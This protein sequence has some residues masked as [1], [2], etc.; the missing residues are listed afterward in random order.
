M[1]SKIAVTFL[2]T[3]VSVSVTRCPDVNLVRKGRLR[4]VDLKAGTSAVPAGGVTTRSRAVRA[5]CPPAP[6]PAREVHRWKW[7]RRRRPSRRVRRRLPRNLARAAPSGRTVPW[8]GTAVERRQASAPA[9]GGRRK[10]P[11]PWRV[12]TPLACGHETLRLPAFRFLY[13][14]FVGANQK[15]IRHPEVRA[16]RSLEGCGR[17]IGAVSFEAR[18]CAPSTSG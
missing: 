18:R 14:L 5:S 11:T 12:R 4:E 15:V 8:A 9:S 16:Q 2:L 1:A 6:R 17:G 13:F 3:S 10:P 7:Q